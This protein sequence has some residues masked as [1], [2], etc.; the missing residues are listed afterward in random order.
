VGC[1]DALEGTPDELRA[2]EALLDSFLG[3]RDVERG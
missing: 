1:P 3:Q 2:D